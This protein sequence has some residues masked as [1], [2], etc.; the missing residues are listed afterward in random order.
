MGA[1]G[2]WNTYPQDR[3]KHQTLVP[4]PDDPALWDAW[5]EQLYNWRTATRYLFRDTESLYDRPD[6]AWT[7][8]A[9]ASALIPVFD[10]KF[11]DPN[12]AAY[13]IDS[14]LDEAEDQFG[15]YDLV[16]LWCGYP[17]LGYDA[18]NC[19]DLLFD[20]P[21]G[22]KGLCEIG[23]AFHRRG[24]R[25]LLTYVPWDTGT[26]PD[27]RPEAERIAEGVR[28]LDADGVYLD[29]MDWGDTGLRQALD[30]IRPGLVVC[31]ENTVT[32]ENLG[33]H[34]MCWGQWNADSSAP[35]V[36][37][38]KWLEPRHMQYQLH[39]WRLD[40]TEELQV[41][42]MN[43]SGIVI[44][45]NVFGSQVRW[46]PHNRS[47]VRAMLPIQR[48]F[49]SLFSNL[50]GWT[51]LV[52]TQLP[53]VYSSLWQ[54]GGLRLWTLVNRA[55]HAVQG[56][57]LSVPVARGET[58]FDLVNGH[59]L[60]NPTGSQMNLNAT[61]EPRGLG[62]FLA[63]SPD[64]ELGT[65]FRAFLESQAA[66]SR[67]ACWELTKAEPVGVPRRITSPSAT[68]SVPLPNMI[69]IP[70]AQVTM[71]TFFV[72]REDRVALVMHGGPDAPQIASEFEA[73]HT[74][75][76]VPQ[77][78]AVAV[79]RRICALTPYAIDLTPVTNAQFDEFLASSHYEPRHRANFLAHWV[80]GSPPLDKLD[81]PVVYVDLEDARAYAAWANK[82]LVTE[83]EWQYAAQG[84]DGR[85]YPWGNTL[86]AGTHNDGSTRDTTPVLAFPAGRS[87]FGVFDMSGNIWEWTD[88]EQSDGR[89]RSCNLRGGSYLRTHS[90]YIWAE[91]AGRW[92]KASGSDWYAP[93]GPQRCDFSTSLILFWAGMDRRATI[94]FRCAVNLE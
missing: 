81:H 68:P 53:Q 41:S 36:L 14:M 90:A 88:S 35:G 42:W 46:N 83:E 44:W 92:L 55:E 80:N 54:E 33:E 56:T 19:F 82:R 62:C 11:Y 32:L 74:N 59:Q 65:D 48:R 1:Y 39:R 7:R 49:I 77:L 50:N 8:S 73:L 45:E 10:L 79:N 24:V 91:D 66:R 3:R 64:E 78:H 30:A 34:H 16:V 58:F 23:S 28:L 18:R 22:K 9:F 38:N 57:L 40:H 84:N 25:L 75:P 51:P 26:R 12:D 31:T 69:P 61:I 71:A 87:P 17:Q 43:G 85:A 2:K 29:C 67:R 20:L 86:V 70:G 93:Q 5:R 63:A 47:F 89:T 60:D 72:V 37:R 76:N 52:E 21:R 6:L 27:P 15:G 13:K 4:A 94:G